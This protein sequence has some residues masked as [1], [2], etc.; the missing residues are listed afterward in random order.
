MEINIKY[1]DGV[2]EFSED[3]SLNMRLKRYI[4]KNFYPAFVISKL[5]PI[6]LIGGSIRDLINART[7]KD[8]D[9]IVVGNEHKEWVLQVLKRF[10]IDYSFN[11]FGGFKFSY[12]GVKIDLWTA[13]DLFSSMQYNVDGVYY[14]LAQNR[15][16]SLTFKD[17]VDKG[18]RE[19]NPE[20][21]I[22]VDREKKLLKFE[23]EYK[24]N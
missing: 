15:L 3:L 8:L 23:E 7:P 6:Y 1:N 24:K 14:D 12:N 19:I 4:H 9:F 22:K 10:G 13:D 18:L 20:N 11:R 17:F 5:S 21:N 16:L 2:D